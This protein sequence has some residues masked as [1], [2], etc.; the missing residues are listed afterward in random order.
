M[1]CTVNSTLNCLKVL[2]GQYKFYLAF[3]LSLCKD[4]ISDRF[5]NV[6]KHTNMIPIVQGSL[7]YKWYLPEKSYINADDFE[8]YNQLVDYLIYLDKNDDKYLEYFKWKRDY[9]VKTDYEQQACCNLCK[10]LHDPI[11]PE[12]YD[13]FKKWALGDNG[14]LCFQ[15]NTVSNEQNF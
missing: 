1:D 10:K 6:V 9:I 4:Y 3:E 13:D 8:N 15:P 14:L 7:N 2:D 12:W 11:V 5:Y